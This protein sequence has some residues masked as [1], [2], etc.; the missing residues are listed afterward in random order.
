MRV[1]E[2]AQQRL[3]VA[4]QRL[5]H[6]QHEHGHRFADRHFDLRQAAANR[7]AFD[8]R[9]QRFHQRR[10]VRRQDLARSEISNETAALFVEAE[11]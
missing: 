4:G 7:Q 8:Q 2:F 3:V 9:A 10:Y 5:Q 6:A 11:Q 1:S